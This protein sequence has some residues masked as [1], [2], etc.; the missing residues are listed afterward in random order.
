MVPWWPVAM[1]SM[2]VT[3]FGVQ[4]SLVSS[5]ATTNQFKAQK[6]YKA[7]LHQAIWY[8]AVVLGTGCMFE[9]FFSW[10]SV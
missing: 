8:G 10:G 9:T 3:F 4:M 1:A 5:S 6:E 2:A 7:Q